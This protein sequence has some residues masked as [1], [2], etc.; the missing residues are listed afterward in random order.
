M[1]R[2]LEILAGVASIEQA[3]KML[4]KLIIAQIKPKKYAKIKNKTR[5]IVYKR[6]KITATGKVCAACRP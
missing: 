3:P 6:F 2:A 1:A 5:K 4:G